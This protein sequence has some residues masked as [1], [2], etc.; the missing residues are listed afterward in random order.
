MPH[1][2]RFSVYNPEARLVQT[3][4]TAE[5]ASLES[6]PTA[7]APRPGTLDGK[8]V[9][10]VD[11]GFGGS[12][13]FMQQLQRWMGEHMPSVTTIRRR[14]RGVRSPMTETRSGTRS[15]RREAMRSSLALGVDR[16]ARRSPRAVIS[17]NAL[18]GIPTA[19]LSTHEYADHVRREMRALGA[20]LPFVWTP[21]PVVSMPP[22]TLYEYLESADPLTGDRVIDEIIAA[23]TESQDGVASGPGPVAMPSEG[24]ASREEFVGPGTE[25]ELQRLF[26]ERG[27]TDGLPV[28]LPTEKRVALMMTGTG[29]AGDELVGEIFN[30]DTKEVI[31]YTVLDIAVVAVMAGARPEH[32]PVILAVAATR[33]SS[34]T[35]STTPFGSM[36]LVNGPIRTEINM[37]S[38]VAAFSPGNL[39]NAV[40]GRAWTLMSICW[41]YARPKVTLWSS[42][43]NGFL[44]NNMCFAE[45]EERS[46][47]TPFHVQKGFGPEES[48]VSVFKGWFVMNSLQAAAKRTIGEEIDLQLSVIPALHSSATIMMDPRRGNSKRPTDSRVKRTSAG[49]WRRTRRFLPEGTRGTDHIDMLVA[50]SRRPGSSRTPV[51]RSW[52]TTNSCLSHYH[53]PENINL[54]VVGGRGSSPV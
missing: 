26:Y 6:A 16:V 13:R 48:V 27:W 54:V 52:R 39:A 29:R 3:V 46:V 30:H 32:L 10:L 35:P 45:N 2:V 14:N 36:L 40:I 31:R 51:G 33:Q 37:N 15:R 50:R 4:G 20:I 47:W 9:Y 5:A 7:L 34:L 21:H 1:S 22:E 28:I 8:T 11:T 44:Y 42:Q 49:G 38:G 23:L 12:Y 17:L 25:D 41:G 19:P 53:N 18:Y 43:G 24:V